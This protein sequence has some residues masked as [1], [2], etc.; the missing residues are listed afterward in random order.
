MAVEQQF[1]ASAR[2]AG[3]LNPLRLLVAALAALLGV[4]IVLPVAVLVLGSF[5]SEP[6][7]ALHVDWSGLTLDNYVEVLTKGG[8][9]GL[10]G[11]SLG[12]AFS[13]TAGALAIGASLAW[14]ATR[15]DVPGRRLIEAVA[16]MPM[17]VPPLVGAFAWDIL[18]SPRSG[19]INLAARALHLPGLVNVYSFAGIGFVFAIYYAP[20]VYL[21]VAAA[22]RNMDPVFEEAAALCGAGRFRTLAQITL[23][24]V[25]PALLS[26][27]LLVFVLLIELFAI[28]AVL[29][30]AGGLHFIS[31]RIWELIGFAPPRVNEASALGVLMLAVTVTLV[32]LQH[33]VVARRSFVTV[34]GKGVRPNIVALGGARWP[35]A[36]LGFAYLLFVV[37]LPYGALLLIALRKGLF[38][39]TLAAVFDPAQLS[40]RQF[41]IAL[42]DA[43][44]QTSL[45][46]SLLVAL[47]T[48]L[49]GG[50][51]YFTIAY[52]VHRTEIAGR[53]M[54]DVIAILPIAIPGL[55]IG[56]G[57]LWSWIS[58]P[59]GIYGTI[60]I[61]I[62]AYVSQFAPQGVRAISASLVQIHPELEESGRICGGSFVTTLR[63]VVIPLA[64]PG[65]L[66]ATILLLV[67]SFREL[68]T[69][70]FL[71]TSNTQVFSVTMFDFWERGSTGLVAVM[72]L[73]QS[74]ILL[75]L[76]VAGQWVRRGGE[77]LKEVPR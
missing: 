52:I 26:A 3:A 44:V 73:V 77:A 25:A 21:F 63:R 16:I 1:V 57:Y 59:I 5:L 42:S 13:G 31:V 29:G 49:L 24:L 56:L 28:P 20:Y 17:F 50:V 43:V 71:Y 53:R 36:T 68:A 11:T 62:F 55:I 27:A 54:L 37:L 32:L 60:W 65:I 35:L 4:L 47:G 7:R 38:F 14:L 61:I 6:P 45:V 8:F 70:L 67:L 66:A 23:P 72:A 10:L 64:W 69:A 33:R 39:S 51:L 12:A 40:L 48:V 19:I 76:V 58:L 22:L 18:A 15:T 74:L 9:G 75:V 30:T 46:N 34:G 2:R 41:G